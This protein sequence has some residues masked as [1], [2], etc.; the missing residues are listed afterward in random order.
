M[1][2]RIA[3]LAALVTLAAGPQSLQAQER[4]GYGRWNEK[5]LRKAPKRITIQNFNILFK[6]S[7]FNL[8]KQKGEILGPETD[9]YIDLTPELAQEITDEGYNYFVKIFNDAGY[10][11]LIFDADK[12]GN[13]KEFKNAIKKNNGAAINNGVANPVTPEQAGQWG[14]GDGGFISVIATGVNQFW[15]GSGVKP[16]KWVKVVKDI[17]KDTDAVG[18]FITG[19]ID[20]VD[21]QRKENRGSSINYKLEAI[22]EPGIRFFNDNR[23]GQPNAG[24]GKNGA[25]RW[26]AH[27]IPAEDDDSWIA[28]SEFEQDEKKMHVRQYYAIHPEKYKAFAVAQLKRYA[29]QLLATYEEA[30]YK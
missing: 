24:Y 8:Q 25:V 23:F 17:S 9:S 7:T 2:L 16:D 28:E 20:F 21:P 6:T 4:I 3:L 18:L 19:M 30:V 22:N 11:I 26:E 10:E 5:T 15:L 12:I 27:V 14:F 13:H 29:D 1:V